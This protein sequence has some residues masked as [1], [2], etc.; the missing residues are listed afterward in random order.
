MKMGLYHIAPRILNKTTRGSTWRWS[1][2]ARW[3]Q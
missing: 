2:G 1:H 3:R